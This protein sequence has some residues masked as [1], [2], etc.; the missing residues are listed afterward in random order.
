VAATAYA[1]CLVRCLGQGPGLTFSHEVDGPWRRSEQ[2]DQLSHVAGGRGQPVLTNLT[3]ANE[4]EAREL[5]VKVTKMA[6]SKGK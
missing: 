6:N 5:A 4:S 3:H 2:S 1:A